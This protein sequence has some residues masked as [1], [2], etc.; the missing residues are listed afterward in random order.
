[1][2]RYL[3]LATLVVALV[4]A[5][6][7]ALGRGSRLDPQ[8]TYASSAR[9]TPGS[10]MHESGARDLRPQAV[11]GDAPWALSALPECFHQLH[12]ASGSDAFVRAK[13]PS[14]VRRV[15]AGAFLVTAD[16]RLRIG[17]TDAT[18]T[19]GEN[20][21]HIPAPARFFIARDRLL[22]ETRSA[23]RSTLRTYEIVAGGAPA[24]VA[25]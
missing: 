19:R 24:F 10:P 4:L 7:L 22:L 9:A 13:M 5:A 11:T 23:G 1:M 15:G 21:L 12:F 14:S 2:A 8:S 17:A 16:C 20:V 6:M 3:A 18:V 25:K